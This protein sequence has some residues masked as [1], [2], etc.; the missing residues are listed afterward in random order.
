MRPVALAVRESVPG[1]EEQHVEPARGK[2]LGD[3]G[4]PPPAPTTITSRTA[5]AVFLPCQ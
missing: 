3:D 1:F 4:A 2:L 5:S